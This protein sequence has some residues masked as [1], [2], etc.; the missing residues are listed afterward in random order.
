[1]RSARAGGWLTAALGVMQAV[2]RPGLSQPGYPPDLRI[3]RP[4]AAPTFSCAISP[5]SCGRSPAAPSS[6]RTRSGPASNIAT[7]YVARAKPDGYTLYP[8]AATTVAASMHLFKNPP[9]DVGKALQVAATTS[10]L[11]L[12]AR[13][14]RRSRPTRRVAELTAAMKQKGSKASYAVAANPGR[15]MGA[16]YKDTAGLEAVEVQYRTAA[17]SLN[18]MPSGKLDYGL[19]DPIFALAQQREGRLRVLAV[20]TGKRLQAEPDLP[21]MTELGVPMDLDL[22]WGV[23]VPTGTPKPIIDKDQCWFTTDRAAPRRPRSSST[24]RRRSL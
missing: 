9:V 8:F 12:H 6:S 7:E 16:I 21:T 18:E 4:A 23:M 3:S 14:R 17:D 13:G 11:R 22:W 24:L 5:R 20:S 2:R 10:N 19:H 15:I 1:M